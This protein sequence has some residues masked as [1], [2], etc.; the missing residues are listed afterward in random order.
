MSLVRGIM[1][2]R[3][4][5]A[6]ASEVVTRPVFV[7]EPIPD[8]CTPEEFGRLREAI[9]L[10]DV[11]SPNAE[12]LVSFFPTASSSGGNGDG[13]L[14]QEVMAEK[15][16]RLDSGKYMNAAL[17]VREGAAGCTT[18]VGGNIKLH[19]AAFHRNGSRVRDPTGGGNT[20]L[21]ALAMGMT[22]R[23]TPAETSLG[24]DRIRLPSDKVLLHRNLILGL[25]H[26]TIA[27]A[28]AIEQVGMPNVSTMDF[29]IWNGES[30][31]D[32]FDSYL[33]DH[34]R[35]IASQLQ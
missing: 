7:W 26:A 34:R 29:G 1:A 32:R 25:V 5:L 8:L 27:A 30:Y 24:L 28:Y 19:L 17:V 20:F 13:S 12:E 15:L 10:V 6:A 18:Y 33:S 21:G 9:A 4:E 16:L 3:K 31:R 14:S 11:V 2:R 22:G 23:V 35:H